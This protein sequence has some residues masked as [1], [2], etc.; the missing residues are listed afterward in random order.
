MVEK[1]CNWREEKENYV[2]VM[3]NCVYVF[4]NVGSGTRAH[5]RAHVHRHTQAAVGARC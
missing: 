1:L 5:A 3:K 4:Y 2:D